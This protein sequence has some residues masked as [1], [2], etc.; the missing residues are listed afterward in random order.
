[1]EQFHDNHR[2]Q[3]YRS[4]FS[5]VFALALA[6][7]SAPQARAGRAD[8]SS[9]FSV[10]VGGR[11]RPRQSAQTSAKTSSQDIARIKRR[12]GSGEPLGASSRAA[13]RAIIARQLQERVELAHL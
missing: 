13:A 4:S 5:A 11:H 1:M 2:L 9:R 3:K 10:I 8:D 6:Q 12:I 7:L